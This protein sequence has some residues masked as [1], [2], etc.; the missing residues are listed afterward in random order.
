MQRFAFCVF[1]FTAL[2]I[3]CA[4][5]E[6]NTE[7]TGDPFAKDNEAFLTTVPENKDEIFRVMITSDGYNLVQTA[8]PESI[9]RSDD[10]SG[11]K[12]ICE[13]LNKY[14]K[15][16]E[17][18]EAILSVSLYPDTGRIMKVRPKRLAALREIDELL[19]EDIQ[20]W[21]FVSPA[22]KPVSP[23]RFDVHY[24]IVLKKNQSDEEIIKEVREKMK[25][26]TG[27]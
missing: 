26:K 22:K 19:V 10:K 13:E 12:F 15:I 17:V 4:T 16:N 21:S 8:Y 3:G 27:Q 20:R 1:A 14:N 24:R 5:A 6:K 25:E 11:D 7:K 9:Q 23:L 18:R 2:L